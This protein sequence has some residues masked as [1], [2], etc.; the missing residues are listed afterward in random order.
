MTQ[1]DFVKFTYHNLNKHRSCRLK[2]IKYEIIRML[3]L[4]SVLLLSEAGRYPNMF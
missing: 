2:E 3:V 1:V 4:F